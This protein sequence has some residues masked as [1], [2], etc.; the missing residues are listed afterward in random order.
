MIF[1]HLQ[2][3]K[4]N[5]C[6]QIATEVSVHCFLMLFD[7]NMKCGNYFDSEEIQE[8]RIACVMETSSTDMESDWGNQIVS[9][10]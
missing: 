10:N 8:I 6:N 1:K 5:D 9:V 4:Q 7:I 3:R 2:N